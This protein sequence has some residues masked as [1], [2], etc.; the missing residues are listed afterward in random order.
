MRNLTFRFVY[1]MSQAKFEEGE[2]IAG[3]PRKI[4]NTFFD[5]RAFS[6]PSCSQVLENVSWRISDAKK[7]SKNNLGHYNFGPKELRGMSPSAILAK[8]K[9]EKGIDWS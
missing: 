5:A 4:F 8:L 6:L 2:D 1:H 7:N 9:E 3:L